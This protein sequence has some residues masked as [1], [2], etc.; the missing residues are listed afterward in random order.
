MKQEERTKLTREKIISAAIQEFG[1]RS[2]KDASLNAICNEHHISKGLLYHNFKNKDDLYLECLTICYSR[3]ID[4]LAQ[5]QL[6]AADAAK[7]LEYALK[8]RQ[9]FFEENPQF[10]QLFFNSIFAPPEH[11]L[12]EIDSI[13]KNYN[14]YVEKQY[15]Q[16]LEHLELR[17]GISLE[18]AIAYL[19]MFQ[20][21]YNNYFR[22]AYLRNHDIHNLID[23]HEERL[24]E[25]LNLVLYGIA[26]AKE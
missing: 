23:I 15:Y 1:N 16:I 26:K 20:E 18:Q 6:N 10:T 17:D 22:M 25:L 21:M 11:L 19:M 7:Q 5:T 4:N 9:H 24:L 13:R 8:S 3:M 2:Y 14:D 12:T